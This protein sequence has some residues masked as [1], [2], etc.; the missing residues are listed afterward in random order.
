MPSKRKMPYAPIHDDV[1]LR[2]DV[3]LAQWVGLA[4]PPP[5]APGRSFERN[6]YRHGGEQA[7]ISDV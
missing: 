4:P 5:S 3:T 6:V 1:A 2:Y 7:S